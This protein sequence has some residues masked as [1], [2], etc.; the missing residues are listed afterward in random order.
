MDSSLHSKL[1]SSAGDLPPTQIKENHILEGLK[2]LQKRKMLREPPSIRSKWGYK[3]CMDSNEG[4]YSPGIKCSS[5]KEQALCMPEEIGAICQEHQK[6]FTYDLDSHEDADDSSSSSLALL[7]EGPSQDCRHYCNKITHS[8]SDSLFG[9][10]S[11]KMHL[12]GKG[13]YLSS[14]EKPEKLTSLVNELNS[15]AKS[16]T[17]VKLPVLQIEKSIAANVSWKGLHLHLS[18]S[19]DNDI[20]DELH[21]ETSSD[22][23]NPSD[24][25]LIPV[26]DKHAKES[27]MLV[28]IKNSQFVSSEKEDNQVPIHSDIKPKVCNFI[29]QQKH[30]EKTSSKECITV[31]FDAEDGKPIEFSSHQTGVVTVTGNE[32]SIKHPYTGP[33]V[34]T[35]EYLLQGIANLQN[36]NDAQKL[37]ISRTPHN[38]TET[39]TRQDNIGNENAVASIACSSES[40]ERHAERPEFQNSPQPKLTKPI[41]SITTKA[42]F[43]SFMH[44]AINQKQKVTKIP[45]RGKF[46]PQKT[47]VTVNEDSAVTSLHCPVT[48]EKSPLSLVKCSIFKKAE[49]PIQNSDSNVHIPKVLFHTP[50]NSKGLGRS[51]WCKAQLSEATFLPQHTEKPTDYRLREPPT[52][53]EHFNLLPIEA[54]YPSSPPPHPGRSAP[55]LLKPNYNHSPPVLAKSGT[56]CPIETAQNVVKLSSPKGMSEELVFHITTSEMQANKS[57][58]TAKGKLNHIYK[59]EELIAQTKHILG[60]SFKMC[61]GPPKHFTNKVSKTSNQSIFCNNPEL[62]IFQD[63]PSTCMSEDIT[64]LQNASLSKDTGDLQKPN[65]FP[66]SLDSHTVTTSDLYLPEMS[67]SPSPLSSQGSDAANMADKG[68]KP[69][70]PVGLKLLIR[71]P[72]LLRKH[73]NLPG[74]QEKDSMNAASRS[75]GNSVNHKQSDSV[76]LTTMDTIE[77]RDPSAKRET[78]GSLGVVL[79]IDTPS[80]FFHETCG[81]ID[82]SEGIESKL[83]KRSVSSSNKTCLK[84]ALGMNG[85][86]ARSQSSSLHTG[87]KS[88]GP[89]TQGIGK[90]RTQ[91]ITNT[92]E[93]GNSL[94]RQNSIAEG[95]PIKAISGSATT[96][97][98]VL[99]TTKVPDVSYSRQG[100]S[101]SMSSSNSQVSSPSKLPFQRSQKGDLYFNISKSESCKSPSQ[102]VVQS[103]SVHNEKGGEISKH[104]PVSKKSVCRAEIVSELSTSISSEQILPLQKNLDSMQPP[105]KQ[106]GGKMVLQEGCLKACDPLE[107]VS[108]CCVLQPTIEE[109]VMLCIHENMQKGQGQ[110]KCP[111]TDTKQ[112]YGGPSIANWFGFRKSKVPALRGVKSD[113]SKVKTEMKEV[114]GLGLGSKKTKSEKRKDKKKAEPHHEAENELNKTTWNCG[115]LHSVPEGVG[116]AKAAQNSL[117]QTKC[118]QKNSPATTSSGKDSF[119]KELLHR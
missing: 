111:L 95:F 13:S 10:E 54:R 5:I 103:R 56:G 37:S 16:Y 21:A 39:G 27:D 40:P 28:K 70:V 45:S 24:L 74:K 65:S 73:S 32:I 90:V 71:S 96:S 66:T 89:S 59:K 72:Q 25:L 80:S 77:L 17:N 11:D 43:P 8:V 15:E 81:L 4:I 115:I 104:Q 52:R 6:A 48:L 100:S 38:A 92:S 91:I 53:D 88:P 47:K 67:P 49:S 101:G 51:D 22:E 23:K 35:T 58:V 44:A 84:P 107:Q 1:S 31:I 82:R 99:T 113:L 83:V 26:V 118:E 79:G 116:N 61:H 114:K 117:S 34:E 109:K 98:T 68:L 20:L 30:M 76:S 62:C 87:E 57:P 64:P 75:C 29:K 93:R 12:P 63:A 97:D 102:R 108:T 105:H 7:Y 33:N 119:M 69:C 50:Q 36:A 106:G 85:A 41:C 78:E 46:S 86:K 60:Q 110:S 112:K 3:D 42:G 94:S 14:K 55:L 18:D 19:D 9:W 2:K